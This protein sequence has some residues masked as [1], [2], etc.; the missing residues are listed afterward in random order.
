M[1]SEKEARFRELSRPHLQPLA[2]LLSLLQRAQAE[3]V[4]LAAVTNAPRAN[5]L[6]LLE[7]FGL[8]AE[9]A[10]VSQQEAAAR[11][12]TLVLAEDC[13]EAKPSPVPY[14]LAMQRLGVQPV[15]CIVFEDSVSGATAGVRAGAQ[16]VGVLT[17][18]GEAALR[19]L[20][21]CC[22]IRDYT[23]IDV[24]KMMADMS[25]FARP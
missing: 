24:D 23:Q 11:F 10:S 1:R 4:L 14:Q 8:A 7:L 12:D 15:D 21:C 2:G 3:G 17:S 18:Q 25:D 6:M 22:V 16:V 13:A 9:G 5:V 19:S 20:G